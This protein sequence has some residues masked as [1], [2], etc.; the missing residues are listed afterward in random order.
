MNV[1]EIVSKRISKPFW[2]VFLLCLGFS[3]TAFGQYPPLTKP[4]LRDEGNNVAYQNP[5]DSLQADSLLS[6]IEIKPDVRTIRPEEIFLHLPTRFAVRKDLGVLYKWDELER[7]PG[8]VLS[9]GQMG[10]PYQHFLYGLQDQH[11]PDRQ[12]WRNPITQRYNIYAR[13]NRF[14][15]P[16]YDT[17]TPYVNADFA[18]GAR[19]FQRIDATVSRNITPQWNMTLFYQGR[20]V[21][22]A[23]L[24][25][26]T[27]HTTVFA[28]S[29][30]TSRNE[31]YHLF[32]NWSISDLNDDLNGGILRTLDDG[33]LLNDGEGTFTDN[34][35]SLDG[36]FEK[37]QANLISSDANRKTTYRQ[38]V[39]DQYYHLVQPSDSSSFP[40]RLTLRAMLRAD[41]NNHNFEDLSLSLSKLSQ[42]VVPIY[43][44]LDT[45][46]TQLKEIFKS[47]RYQ[48]LSGIS[49]SLDKPFRFH[50]DGQVSYEQISLDQDSLGIT[51]LN[52]YDIEGR[53]ELGFSW[54][55]V[56]ANL[57][58]RV[59]DLFTPQN[60]LSVEGMLFP[61]A[62]RPA[63]R[64]ADSIPTEQLSPELFQSPLQITGSFS[65]WGKNPSLFQTQYV[66][67]TGNLY[68]PNP[69]LENQQFTQL[70]ARIAW[71]PPANIRKGDTLLPSF[72]YAELFSTRAANLIYYDSQ[73]R[74]GQ[75]ADPLQWVGAT[76]G[77]RTH[78]FA[79]TYL[80]GQFTWQRGSTDAQDDFQW[81]AEY[82]PEF[83]AKTSYYYE[84]RS[85]SIAA[86]FKVGIDV[87]YFSSY[88]GFVPD[89]ASGEFFPSLYQ[90][91][92]YVVADA[93]F[94]TQIKQAYLFFKLS[95]ANEG[96]LQA[97]YYTT[98]FYPML[99]RTLSLGISW[100][101]FD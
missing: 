96:L 8:F 58:Q 11:V 93:Y 73:M 85:L 64:T 95:H 45:A 83:W 91:P 101:F 70:K 25:F 57:H 89:I 59:S 86:I 97:G 88:Q 100:A 69:D 37:E 23:H 1:G 22:G 5:L 98:P 53:G 99:E 78:V 29:N 24:Q 67:S 75:A 84:N 94:A 48:A 4:G 54:G 50:L 66:P 79:K 26:A 92:G 15:V 55:K 62:R 80:E 47:R 81:Y 52:Q 72:F 39:V 60:R 40:Q 9:L 71:N 27:S 17:K 68:Q 43:P 34:S 49:Y 41:N 30:Y 90:V 35:T 6:D 21:E 7:E 12:L 14:Q 76:I 61:L 87:S 51:R 3:S 82:L 20:Q 18:Q 31:K 13:N 74:V 36:K 10:K 28:S 63:V 16:Y 42:H 56:R 19:Q 65:R 77:L 2:G 44:T 38:M 32:A 46:T 33:L